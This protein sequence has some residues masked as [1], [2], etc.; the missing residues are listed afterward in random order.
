MNLVIVC[1]LVFVVLPELSPFRF[2]NSPGFFSPHVI[3]LTN[4]STFRAIKN[5]FCGWILISMISFIYFIIS[6]RETLGFDCC[7]CLNVGRVVI[8]GGVEGNDEGWSG[9]RNGKRGRG[10]SGKRKKK[11]KGNLISE[12]TN[13]T[14]F[15]SSTPP[16]PLSVEKKKKMEEREQENEECR[17]T[18]ETKVEFVLAQ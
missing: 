2:L 14:L 9:R 3:N 8:V 18:S 11:R 5:K 15:S 4:N 6:S 12:S 7:W 1:S 13:L 16:S 17:G 10:K